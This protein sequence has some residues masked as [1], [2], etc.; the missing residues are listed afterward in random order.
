MYC[1]CWLLPL[2]STTVTVICYGLNEFSGI[3]PG[4][5]TARLINSGPGQN[6]NCNPS[7][8]A[9]EVLVDCNDCVA[10]CATLPCLAMSNTDPTH[11]FEWN[12]GKRTW[13]PILVLLIKPSDP[14]GN[15]NGCQI[16]KSR[17]QRLQ[18]VVKSLGWPCLQKCVV[19]LCWW[20]PSWILKS[21]MGKI[22]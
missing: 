4:A 10:H 13:P 9:W 15:R 7:L 2:E 22:W 19:T 16:T 18:I 14:N 17:S 6:C 21:L 8:D 11:A 1:N 5:L 12:S 20:N 3:W